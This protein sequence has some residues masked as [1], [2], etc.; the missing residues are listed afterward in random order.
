MM[1]QENESYKIP[2]NVF[3]RIYQTLQSTG[4]IGINVSTSVHSL[5]RIY[6]SYFIPPEEA[7]VLPNKLIKQVYFKPF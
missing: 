3:T 5:D 7:A 1:T 4:P 6:V 2:I